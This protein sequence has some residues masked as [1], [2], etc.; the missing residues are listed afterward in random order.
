MD[1]PAMHV[2]SKEDLR[3]YI[4]GA[5]L[6][7]TGGGGA[8]QVAHNL[9]DKS[10]VENVYGIGSS[11]V[12]ETMEIATA[13][14]VFAPSAIWANQDYKSALNSYNRLIP[15][16][17]APRGVLPVEVGAVNGIVPAII[18]ALSNAYLILDSQIDRSMPEMDMGLF[19][20]HVPY[21]HLEMVTEDGDEKVNK[22]YSEKM[23]DAMI[24]E[25][26]ILNAMQDH[27]GFKGV[28]GFATYLMTGADLV[29][30]ANQG[31]I[32]HNTFEYARQI[33]SQMGQPDF[34]NRIFQVIQQHLGSSFRPYRLFTGYLVETKEQAHAQDYGYAD[35]ISDDPESAMGARIY[36]SNENMIA[37]HLLWVLVRDVPVPIETGPMAIGPDSISYLLLEGGNETFKA[38][39]SFSNEAFQEAHGD[40]DLFK[41]NRVAIIGIPEPRLRSDPVTKAYAREITR[42]REAFGKTYDGVYIPIERLN[43]MCP[44][45]DV[46]KSSGKVTVSGSIPGSVIRYTTDGNTPGADSPVLKD[47]LELSAVAGRVLKA[48][49]FLQDGSPALTVSADFSG[50]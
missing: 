15:G 30:Y 19:H 50:F 18:A 35:F 8:K 1:H 13:A 39:Y 12:P 31:W 5:T 32:F 24:P 11:L 43:A 28:G 34:E 14:Q 36:Y 6:L 23:T 27:P 20:L 22:Y 7:A 37:Y 17:H 10:G 49:L 9:L 38:G 33:G 16:S 48:R 45:V 2:Y 46:K 26:D 40:P 41:T 42:A 3:C 44:R 4:E 21:R 25:E 47:P 29:S